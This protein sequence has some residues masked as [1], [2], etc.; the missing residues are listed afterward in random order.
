[1]AAQEYGVT[2]A[3]AV[4][5]G[6]MQNA[7]MAPDSMVSGSKGVVDIVVANLSPVPSPLATI[8]YNPTCHSS[9]G[10]SGYGCLCQYVDPG[11]GTC[12]FPWRM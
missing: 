2:T 4:S 10:N 11:H 6:G 5:E 12:I 3:K 1:M 9:T 7:T 8:G